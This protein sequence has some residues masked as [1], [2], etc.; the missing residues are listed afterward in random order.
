MRWEWDV[1]TEQP[2]SYSTIPDASRICLSGCAQKIAQK[3]GGQ[4]NL[5]LFA[6]VAFIAGEQI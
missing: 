4:C 2:E 3:Q 1:N 6:W 5:L